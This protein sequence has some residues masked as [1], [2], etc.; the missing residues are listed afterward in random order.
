VHHGEI[1]RQ[2]E[3]NR[4]LLEG[5]R[6]QYRE[7]YVQPGDPVIVDKEMVRARR[8]NYADQAMV[9]R[10]RLDQLKKDIMQQKTDEKN[11]LIAI[12]QTG[13]KAMHPEE[14]DL[15]IE[16]IRK[17]NLKKQLAESYIALQ[18]ELDTQYSDSE[19]VSE[20]E[21]KNRQHIKFRAY[22]EIFEQYAGVSEEKNEA[23]MRVLERYEKMLA[24]FAAQF[25]VD[26]KEQGVYERADEDDYVTQGL[27]ATDALLIRKFNEGDNAENLSLIYH[28]VNRPPMER[29]FIYGLIER[30]LTG[31]M[32]MSD[33]LSITSSYIPSP[34]KIL[35]K[36]TPN[37]FLSFFGKNLYTKKIMQAIS[38]CEKSKSA[39]GLIG[40]TQAILSNN[41]QY[42]NEDKYQE[43]LEKNEPAAIIRERALYF[44][45]CLKYSS[46]IQILARNKTPE[47]SIKIENYRK[48]ILHDFV[49]VIELDNSLPDNLQAGD[50]DA[51]A[52]EAPVKDEKAKAKKAKEA[53]KRLLKATPGMINLANNVARQ[54]FN[55]IG[56][57]GSAIGTVAKDPAAAMNKKWNLPA[58]VIASIKEAGGSDKLNAIADAAKA[59]KPVLNTFNVI[60][61]SLSG[62]LF[63]LSGI[64]YI[65]GFMTMTAADRVVG[66]ID[67]LNSSFGV[68]NSLNTVCKGFEAG[69]ASAEGIVGGCLSLT[70]GTIN[71][72]IGSYQLIDNHFVREKKLETAKQGLKK[73]TTR[74]TKFYADEGEERAEE[75]LHDKKRFDKNI[76]L[77]SEKKI[78]RRDS[79]AANKLVIAGLSLGAGIIALAGGPVIAALLGLSAVGAGIYG[80]ATSIMDKKMAMRE[81]IDDYLEINDSINAWVRRHNVAHDS[82]QAYEYRER[83]RRDRIQSQGF[84]NEKAFFSHIM[85]GHAIR[86]HDRIFGSRMK[87][88]ITYD[89]LAKSMGIKID[90]HKGYP[91]VEMIHSKLTS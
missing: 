75:L 60:G 83:V 12:D 55:I 22:K 85:M 43:A 15:A 80:M 37:R 5:Y 35:E 65:K 13:M 20:E 91:T 84:S 76:A 71:A 57:M 6:F 74:L 89:N 7:N 16:D 77:L 14:A 67:L 66:G 4:P 36:L 28:L 17:D 88:A 39:L 50:I 54:P 32:D 48:I 64:D 19:P 63:V 11:A 27:A 40:D 87:D 23:D 25:Q 47:N 70:I 3:L 18:R 33:V 29:L 49:K 72:G 34:S 56:S 81:V 79:S 42:E 69:C 58:E 24:N 61:T 78:D 68:G 26:A 44:T 46:E 45:E 10:N 38:L 9:H 2:E 86:I 41:T 31:G 73:E 51:E 30:D 53:G 52:Y 59:I 21:W 90:L 62:I 82:K 1:N 8:N